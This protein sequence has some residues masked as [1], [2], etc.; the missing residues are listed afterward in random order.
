MVWPF[1][2]GCNPTVHFGNCLAKADCALSLE[3]GSANPPTPAGIPGVEEGA[4]RPRPAHC[5]FRQND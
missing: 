2:M 1:A 5:F 3:N 4:R